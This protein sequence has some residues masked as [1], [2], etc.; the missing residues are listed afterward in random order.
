MSAAVLPFRKPHKRDADGVLH[1]PP[2]VKKGTIYV[3]FGRRRPLARKSRW[4]IVYEFCDGTYDREEG[5]GDWKT[6][7]F[8]ARVRARK[9]GFRV[10]DL[11]CLSRDEWEKR[12]A[13][14]IDQEPQ[15]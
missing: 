4:F 13:D 8:L 2:P 3:F 10:S 15:S 9:Y 12:V 14:A 7:M 11:S 6:A 5:P 1:V